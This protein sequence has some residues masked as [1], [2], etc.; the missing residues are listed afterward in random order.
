MELRHLKYFTCLYEE[1]SVTRA[2]QR[3]NIVQPALSMQIA[4][5]E[6]ELGQTLF[7]RSSKGMAP[8]EAGDQ[9]YRLFMPILGQLLAARQTL[10]DRSGQIGG[11][12]SAGLIASAANNALASTLA[13]FVEHHRQVEL[14][15]T[16]GYSQE[17]IAKVLTGMLD[18]AVINQS[19]QYEHLI[20]HDIFDEELLVATGAAN[21]LS[22]ALPLPLTSLA[23]FK[24][25]LPSRRHGLRRVIDQ[26][27]AAQGVEV[28]PQLEVDDLAVIEDFLRRSDW[29]SVLPA[30]VLHRGLHEGALRAYPLAAPGISRRMVCVHDARRPLTPAAMLFI[31]MIGKTMTTALDTIHF[32]KEGPIEEGDHGRSGK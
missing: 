13:H 10:I 7:E 3:L 30:T 23:G 12:I 24:L 32:Y 25:V 29:V 20:G 6:E 14:C 27:L 11:R 19:F 31:E 17:L 15:V 8:T 2:A 9:A 5:L 1:G 21:R 26:H 28:T 18:F 16:S 4:R 22:G